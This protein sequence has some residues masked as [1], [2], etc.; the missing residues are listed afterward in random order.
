MATEEPKRPRG[1]RWFGLSS[2]FFVVNSVREVYKCL[3]N[4]GG[5]ASVAEPSMPLPYSFRTSDG[6]TWKYVY[7][8]SESGFSSHAT[9]DSVPLDASDQTSD[10]GTVDVV[11]VTA[12]SNSWPDN[13]TC[14]VEAVLANNAFRVQGL[15]VSVDS[16]YVD[17][18]VY[19][20]DGAAAGFISPV[21]SYIANS[22]GQY[23]TTAQGNSL[24]EFGTT[25]FV[26]P[27]VT[28]SG[29]GSGASAYCTVDSVSGEVSSVLVIDPG[30]GYSKC[31]AAVTCNAIYAGTAT[32]HPVVSP[33][34]GHGSDPASELY[35]R[36][37]K[38]TVDVSPVDAPL[39]KFR[40]VGLL[41][42]PSDA[43]G[44]RCTASRVKAYYSAALTLVA[45]VTYAPSDGETITGASSGAEATVLRA[46]TTYVYFHDVTGSF[47]EGETV[48]SSETS[49]AFTLGAI[50]NPTVN[51]SSGDVLYLERLD[52][53]Q[54]QNTS[55][56]RVSVTFRV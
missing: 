52:P 19:A 8:V 34:A 3:D 41:K 30:S 56:E 36:E 24:V 4:A 47:Q 1:P 54:R 9:S 29:D 38:M 20:Q 25:L 46:N 15:S 42:N 32:L 17:F 6:Y 11:R 53:V 21:T 50:D 43:D 23:V 7:T 55:S 33:I 37:L 40:V 39:V 13:E 31:E 26:S 51:A 10:A 35:S 45:P 49:S 16:H 5:A 27:R 14:T 2:D 28:F 44:N 12:S 18:S 22:S 48:T